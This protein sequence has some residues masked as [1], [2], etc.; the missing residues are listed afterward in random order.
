MRQEEFLAKYQ[1]EWSVLEQWLATRGSARVGKRKHAD[2]VVLD[3]LDFASRYRRTCQQLAIAQRRGYSPLVLERLEQIMQRGHD[4]LYRPAPPRWRRVLEFFGAGFPRLVRRHQRYML[5]SALLF[6]VPLVTMIVLLQLRPELVYSVFKPEDIATFERM[7][8]PADPRHA[9]GRES[10]SNLQMFGHYILNNVSIGFR[11][12]ASGLLF[13]VGAIYV[14]VMNGVVIGSVAGHLTGIGYGLPFWR[15]VVGHSGP[16][17]TAIVLAGGAGL[18]MGWA[19]V[20]PG[21]LSRR[22]ALLDA[23]RDGAQ[24]V[25]GVF[26]ML[27]LAAFIEAY[28][29][30]IGWMPDAVKFS[31]GITLWLAILYWLW[32]G[33]R[34]SS[35]AT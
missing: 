12:F 15:F 7:Y 16:E 26:A 34:G 10:G 13:C 27:V 2:R 24:L 31:V 28:W 23:G 5:I 4:V 9:L 6:F 32:R 29:S 18:R 25:L 30:S 8:N 19:L 3:D 20:A 11:T 22:R 17:L 35:D 14:L 33:G 21:R 1:D